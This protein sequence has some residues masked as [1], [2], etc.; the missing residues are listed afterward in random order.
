MRYARPSP[1]YGR[2][3]K[4]KSIEFAQQQRA[5]MSGPEYGSALAQH[6]R[7]RGDVLGLNP[8]G[9]GE[10]VTTSSEESEA[11]EV[12]DIEHSEESEEEASEEEDVWSRCVTTSNPYCL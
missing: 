6:L 10:A 2:K 4:E 1:G 3:K 7:T 12:E 5:G 8:F 9:G 11:V